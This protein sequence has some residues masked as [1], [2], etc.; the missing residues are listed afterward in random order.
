MKIYK[1]FRRFLLISFMAG[2]STFVFQKC[3]VDNQKADIYQHILKFTDDIKVI[4][5]HEHQ[6]RPDE[7]GFDSVSF[8]HLLGQTYLFHD[9]VSSGLQ[10]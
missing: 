10:Q 1:N 6:R 3:T 5:T 7:F 9:V 8:Y 2:I 4:N